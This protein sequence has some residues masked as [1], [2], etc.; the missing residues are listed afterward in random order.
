MSPSLHQE[1]RPVPNRLV[2]PAPLLPVALGMMAG[3]V[4]DD[5][6]EPSAIWSLVPLFVGLILLIRFRHNKSLVF[7]CCLLAATTLGA[8]RHAIAMRRLPSNHVARFLGNEPIIAHIQGEIITEP[9]ISEPD[10]SLPRAFA[11]GPKTRFV[12]EAKQLEGIKGPLDVTGQMN[13]SVKAPILDLHIGDVVEMTGWFFAPSGPRNPGEYDWGLYQR[14]N[15]IWAQLSADHAESVVRV[16]RPSYQGW[17]GILTTARNRL[18]HYLVDNAFE[19]DNETAGVMAAMILGQ[20]S[21]VSK[22]MNEAF[23]KTGNI[24]FLAASGMNVAWLALVGWGI[25]R[26][27]RI[28]PRLSAIFVGLLILAFVVLAEPQPSILRAGVIGIFVCTTKVLGGRYNSINGL[29]CATIAIA[30]M[31]PTDIFSPA[32]QFSFLATLGLLHFCPLVSAEIA[33]FFARV[34]HIKL[35]E[36]FDRRVTLLNPSLEDMEISRFSAAL[37]WVAYFSAQTLSLSLS[38]WFITTP[39]ACYHFNQFVVWGAFGTFILSPVAMLATTLGFVT[40]LLGLFWP[41]TTIVFGPLLHWS[42]EL[43][44]GCVKV[45]SHLPAA[46]LDGRSPSLLW[47]L[48]FYVVLWIW[49]YHRHWIRWRPG[50]LVAMT[51]LFL[52]WLVPQNWFRGDTDTLRVWML[53]VGDGTGTVIELPNGKTFLCDFGTRSPFDA[54]EIGIN[55]LRHRGIRKIDDVFVSHADFDHFSGI[56]QIADQVTIRRVIL[57]D[58]FEHFAEEHSAGGRFLKG[59]R[60]RHIPIEITHGPSV[61]E[62][63]DGLR[64]ESLWPPPFTQR[65]AP[66]DN[67][68]SAVLRI[69]YE[70]KSILLTGDI[71]QWAIAGLL[72][73]ARQ[74][75]TAPTDSE[76]SNVVSLHADVLSLPHHG[77]V[78]GNTQQFINVVNPAIAIR[79]SGQR[80]AM[81][82]NGIERLVGKRQYLSTAE[83]G[84]VTI[85]IKN[86]EIKVESFIILHR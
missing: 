82:T 53:A 55:F 46:L 84:C 61:F 57:N 40:V 75:S 35:A 51:L 24:H 18:R 52:W 30:L 34:G 28:S 2:Q 29:A 63:A 9:T 86:R 19:S 20:R 13:V 79:S 71:A 56:E 11:M 5:K 77:S 49:A 25:T 1:N 74:A 58:Q 41:S 50:Y 26:V 15:G 85:E 32:F 64:I 27:L 80:K 54:G 72:S 10:P 81:T 8:F 4:I 12:L 21:A 59:L 62:D 23:L 37:R 33:R 67:D 60:D 31:R 42:S 76:K 38:E 73:Q 47:V 22:P 83:A 43:M 16:A 6:L 44:V 70:G 39:L 3:I 7:I 66:S 45:L 78:V 36:S 17:R 14:R 68:T 48:T 65:Q 69:T